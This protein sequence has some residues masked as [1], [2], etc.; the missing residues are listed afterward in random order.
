MTSVAKQK[1]TKF[2][3]ILAEKNVSQNK[4]LVWKFWFVWKFQIFNEGFDGIEDGDG[5]VMAGV[6]VCV[7]M[8]FRTRRN[9]S[10]DLT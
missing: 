5:C 9:Q 4:I 1:Q 10:A 6:C 7:V 8:A 3:E 2:E